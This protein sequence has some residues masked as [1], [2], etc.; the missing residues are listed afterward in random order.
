MA[1]QSGA[2]G[3]L[4]AVLLIRKYRAVYTLRDNI[5]LLASAD[6]ELVV[7]STGVEPDFGALRLSLVVRLEIAQVPRVETLLAPQLLVQLVIGPV[8][9]V[10]RRLLL[11]ATSDLCSNTAEGAIPNF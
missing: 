3:L 7:V 9:G 10:R 5:V 11:F 6:S 4:A 2:L 8:G 1:L